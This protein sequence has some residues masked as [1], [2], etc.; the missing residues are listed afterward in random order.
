MGLDSTH[1]IRYCDT[2]PGEG[3]APRDACAAPRGSAP[4]RKGVRRLQRGRGE[5]QMRYHRLLALAL[6]AVLLLG[7]E[8]VR[9][10]D[11]AKSAL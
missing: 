8:L 11:S 5:V 9:A 3:S 6:G 7:P 4:E 2:V 10:D 1:C